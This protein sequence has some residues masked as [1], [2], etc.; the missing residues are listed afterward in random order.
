VGHNGAVHALQQ[1]HF[2]A[3]RRFAE[4]APKKTELVKSSWHTEGVYHF[5]AHKYHQAIK[6]FEHAGDQA[7]VRS[8]YEALFFDEQKKLGK[9]M[10]T[11]TIKQYAAVIKRM[12]SYA[13][14]SGNK[15]LVSHADELSKHL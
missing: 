7:L 12:K 9:N 5:Q 11:D 15:S 4:H 10:T 3:A 14:K 6:A 2:A 8:C 1:H 13:K